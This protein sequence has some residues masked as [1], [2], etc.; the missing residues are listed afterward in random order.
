VIGWIIR[1]SAALSAGPARSRIAI[2]VCVAARLHIRRHKALLAVLG[3]VA[4]G[5]CCVIRWAQLIGRGLVAVGLM[6]AWLVTVSLIVTRLVT[7]SL[8]VTRLVTVSLIVT[9][10]VAV[11]LVVTRLVTVSLVV[12]WL[13]IIGGVPAA[14]GRNV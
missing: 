3:G 4:V 7:V 10:L 9:R 2:R 6:R 13:V 8:I 1:A 14:G 11:S 5:A 12:G